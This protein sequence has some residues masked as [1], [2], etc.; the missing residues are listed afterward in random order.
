MNLMAFKIGETY[1][2][3]DMKEIDYSILPEIL[4]LFFQ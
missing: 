2:D 4:E 3:G 1:Y